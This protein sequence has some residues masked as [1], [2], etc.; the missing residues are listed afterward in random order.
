MLT[1]CQNKSLSAAL[2]ILFCWL[3]HVGSQYSFQYEF[4]QNL[5]ATKNFALRNASVQDF[6]QVKEEWARIDQEWVRRAQIDQVSYSV[7]D[8]IN[9]VSVFN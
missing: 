2:G 6:A 5:E 4:R 1:I 9:T 8:R 7:H 3:N